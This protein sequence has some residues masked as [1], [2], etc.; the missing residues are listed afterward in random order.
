MTIRPSATDGTLYPG[1]TDPE[2]TALL[3]KVRPWISRESGMPSRNRVE[4]RKTLLRTV[5]F[6]TSPSIE[7]VWFHAPRTVSPSRTQS[8]QNA[9]ETALRP[10]RTKPLRNVDR[11][12]RGGAV[13]FTPIARGVTLV[14]RGASTTND[15]S[16]LSR[17]QPALISG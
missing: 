2:T 13:Q 10:P 15:S 5:R 17:P 9:S 1:N 8:S 12:S 7:K 11:L 6:V 14:S 4:A 16:V 3:T